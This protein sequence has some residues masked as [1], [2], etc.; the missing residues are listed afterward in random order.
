M[1]VV[2]VVIVTT[3]RPS[4]VDASRLQN[5]QCAWQCTA[6]LGNH[7]LAL[8]EHAIRALVMHVYHPFNLLEV[9][10]LFLGSS[11]VQYLL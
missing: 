3:R 10:D 2:Q 8:N 7:I 4:L 9:L 1:M 6:L 11:G 5:R